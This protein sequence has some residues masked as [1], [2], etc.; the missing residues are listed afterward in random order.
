M[1]SL[2][3]ENNLLTIESVRFASISKKTP[4]SKLSFAFVSLALPLLVM[5]VLSINPLSLYSPPSLEFCCPLQPLSSK[6]SERQ[7]PAPSHILPLYAFLCILLFTETEIKTYCTNIPY[8]Y[9]QSFIEHWRN[10]VANLMASRLKKVPKWCDQKGP[11]CIST[12]NC[13]CG[14]WICLCEIYSVF[15]YS[16]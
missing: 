3:F 9:T 5:V 10:E 2:R 13:W 11:F 15:Q 7:L 8:L 6:T 12:K 4:L 1:C 16:V 14:G